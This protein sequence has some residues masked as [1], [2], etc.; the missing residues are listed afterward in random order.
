MGLWVE[1]NG[2]RY[3]LYVVAMSPLVFLFVFFSCFCFSFLHFP[4]Q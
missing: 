3:T 1:G 2:G 4:Q